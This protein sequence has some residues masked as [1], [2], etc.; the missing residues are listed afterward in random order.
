MNNK[1]RGPNGHHPGPDLAGPQQG[2]VDSIQIAPERGRHVQGRH[3]QGRHVQ[4]R[5]GQGRD[6]QAGHARPQVPPLAAQQGNA[7]PRPP[8]A[9][10]QPQGAPQQQ[11][12][13]ALQTGHPMQ[14]PPAGAGQGL[15]QP[16]AA[17]A[18]RPRSPA[19]KL[20]P[21]RPPKP[22]RGR[23][24]K[25]KRRR[26]HP[27]LR[28]F[29]AILTMAL[30]AMIATGVLALVVKKKFEEA[31]PLQQAA[32]ITIP[33]GRGLNSIAAYLE[34][35]GVIRD[36]RLFVA[37]VY[38]KGVQSKLKAGK[39]EIPQGASIEEVVDHLV[40]GKGI[41][42]KVTLVEG[43]TSQQIVKRL[44]AAPHLAGE[45]TV[46]PPEGT[47]LPDTYVYPAD[48]K[49]SEI[50]DMMRAAQQKLI[51]RL[52]QNRQEG[53]PLQSK[54]E[55]LILA[56]IVEKETGIAA[57]RARVAAVFINR[58]RKGMKLQSDP[59]IIYG[60]VGGQGK[61]G[62]PIRRSE[63]AKKTAYNTYQIPRLPPTPICNP[64]SATLEATLNP[65]KTNDLYF[66]AD[67]T[68]GHI[69]AKTLQQHNA[70]VRKWRKLEKQMR[71]KV[72][73]DAALKA[74]QKK[75]AAAAAPA[76][77]RVAS[78]I[79]VT[80]A[81]PAK[82]AKVKVLNRSAGGN[83]ASSIPLPVRKPKRRKR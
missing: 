46:V 79:P 54:Q 42:Y 73:K 30:L 71:T 60:L 17:Q 22:P 61:L 47:L 20:Q 5:D 68:G 15:P 74:M 10:P 27:A 35:D 44:N 8:N 31:G 51:D 53:L 56:S 43:Q 11:P 9:P 59:T 19:E 4:G 57:E 33:R 6:G 37:N 34:R 26:L 2:R 81:T 83:A 72:K 62:H 32:V 52:W 48:M 45:I 39:Y 40:R 24:P 3:V 49:R 16:G 82:P 80:A 7:P 58:L 21:T 64:G 12:A 13:M 29:N 63:L 76:K 66:V 67:G 65:A 69:F 41:S 14:A 18:A 75:R 55:A 50:L 23:R 28:L 77:A 78:A 70:N 38:Y 25:A 36:S 1:P